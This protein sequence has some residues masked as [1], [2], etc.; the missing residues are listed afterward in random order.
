M[1]NS[2][3]NDIMWKIKGNEKKKTCWTYVAECILEVNIPSEK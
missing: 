2:T 3:L 1:D